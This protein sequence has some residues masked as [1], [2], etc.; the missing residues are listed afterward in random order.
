MPPFAPDRSAG[1]A[2]KISEL[3][4][5]LAAARSQAT[6]FEA[7]I[8]DAQSRLKGKEAEIARVLA[9][10]SAAADDRRA[11]EN[12]K[13]KLQADVDAR[14]AEIR[15]L[16]DVAERESTARIKLEKDLDDLRTAM[17]SEEAKRS[18]AA[19]STEQE[20][21]SLRGEVAKLET[22]LSS[23]AER[24]TE[25]VARVTAELGALQAQHGALTDKHRQTTADL[26]GALK[27]RA[28]VEGSLLESANALR[29][30]TSDL[31]SVWSQL[32][33]TTASLGEAEKTKEV[34]RGPPFLSSLAS[35][36]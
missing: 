9:E 22:D 21:A 33:T 31:Q 35:G 20:L 3:D 11:L 5:A 7:K 16:K 15:Q 12:A 14:L 13:S 19:K 25:A 34:R 1:E 10:S 26:D 2:A 8:A 18:Q 36:Y 29:A 28:A 24:A 32:A 23:A 6:S 4:A 17:G 30:S 27:A